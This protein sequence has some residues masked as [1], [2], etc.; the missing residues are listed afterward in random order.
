MTEHIEI[1]ERKT[2]G[3]LVSMGEYAKMFG[4][5]PGGATLQARRGKLQTTRVGGRRMVVT[6]PIRQALGLPPAPAPVA[7]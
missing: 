4:L 2:R 5:T 3:A 1:I 6:A 7:G